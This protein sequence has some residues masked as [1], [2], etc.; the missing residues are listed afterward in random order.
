MDHVFDGVKIPHGKR[1]FLGLS[2]A[3]PLTATAAA[4]CNAPACMVSHY[5]VPREKSV[6]LRFGLLRKFFDD[7]FIMFYLYEVMCMACNFTSVYCV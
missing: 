3:G 2:G 4:D 7:S 5:I 6:P 1:Q